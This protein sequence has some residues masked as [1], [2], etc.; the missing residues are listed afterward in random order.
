[1][2]GGHGGGGRGATAPP[3]ILVYIII[4]QSGIDAA[5]VSRVMQQ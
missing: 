1:M 4:A 3:N 5:A 2:G